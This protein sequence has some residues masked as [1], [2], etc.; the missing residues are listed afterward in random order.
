LVPLRVAASE[1][2]SALAGDYQPQ[3]AHDGSLQSKWVA[4]VESTPQSPQWITLR[5]AAARDVSAVA[6]YGEALDNDGLVAG[7]IQV[8][9][10]DGT[11]YQT[12]LDVPAAPARAWLATF[13]PVATTAVRLLITRS[14]GPS[15]HTDVYE[16]RL[17][18]PPLPPH[19][20]RAHATQQLAAAE[21]MLALDLEGLT[22]SPDAGLE[23]WVG[24]APQKLAL[25]ARYADV[26]RRLEAWDQ[27][28]PSSHVAFCDEVDRLA[29]QARQLHDAHGELTRVWTDRCA[30]VAAA[31]SADAET[32][33][34]PSAQRVVGQGAAVRVALS[35]DS[36]L[37]EAT[38]LGACHA[39][40]R[41]VAFAVEVDG[42]SFTPDGVPV[43]SRPF[44]SHLGSGTE[45]VQTWGH[46]V[47]VERRLQVF[48]DR[49]LVVVGGSVCNETDQEVS[50]GS[51]A[52]LNLARDGTG[53]W[54]A[55]Q[56][57]QS[58]GVVTLSGDSLWVCEPEGTELESADTDRSYAGT[59]LLALAQR[60]PA[61][62]LL[63]GFLTGRE[64]RPRVS[65]R[66]RALESGTALSATQDFLGRRLGPGE[67]IELDS[68]AVTAS[69]DPWSSL[70]A[71]GNDVAAAGV[72]PA[73]TRPTSLWCS[74]YAHRMAMTEDLVLANAAVA[75]QH[76][77]PLGMEIIQLDH[78]WQRGDVTGDWIPNERFP[79]GLPWLAEQ[80]RSKYGFRLGLWISPTDVADVSDLYRDHADWLLRDENG[81]PLRN[82]QWYW[83]PNPDCYE[84][85]ASHPDAADFLRETFARL[86]GEGVSY[87]KI[88]FLAPCGGDHFVQHDPSC[89][90]GWGVLQRAMEAIRAGA[91]PDAFIR[92]C[93]APPLLAVGLADGAYGGNDLLDGGRPDVM[94]VTREAAR[95]LA[96]SYWVHQRLYQREVCDLSIRVQADQE[97]VRLRLAL[98]ALAGCS[99]SLSDELQYLPSSRIR[100]AQQV[101]PPGTP[102][103]R[104]LDLFERAIPS[105]WHVRC[106][107]PF[108]QWHVVGLFN[109]EDQP[110]VRSV[111]LSDLGLAA[112]GSA[113]VFEFWE[114]RFVGVHPGRVE[115]ELPP[116]SSRVLFVHQM[117]GDPQLLGT[118]LHILGGY[119]ELSR[120]EWDADARELRGACRRMPGATG[121]V[122]VYLPETYAPKFDFPLAETS[123]RLTHVGN[124]VW[125]LELEF[126]DTEVEWTIPF[127]PAA[128]SP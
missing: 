4:A 58:P 43:T 41:G 53:W 11:D 70:E 110:Q 100:M 127:E 37:W 120:L 126:P 49:P 48:N 81:R 92:Y 26:R 107:R 46:G 82:W 8:L 114:E 101:L 13:P 88:D 84:L 40:L 121:R 65:A 79:H 21:A 124:R 99:I 117:T 102:P 73:R 87:F 33:A 122:Y 75:A 116:N 6:V 31:R 77:Q 108:A 83:K 54:H 39:A 111:E 29:A 90:R 16:I 44:E 12:V 105:V 91:G 61:T 27:H 112:D 60:N 63:V 123:A 10:P 7:A 15:P 109:L 80:L 94:P 98:L 59:M 104:P 25:R 128:D 89:T 76:F 5:L 66:F 55:G 125:M 30:E 51:A 23:Q 45:L 62:M 36:G 86:A 34:S 85:D 115:L 2:S 18:G 106:E 9:A 72:A 71:Y 22:T 52:L 42:T 119:H 47:R 96:A 113:L 74:W 38:W 68:V 50:L 17:Y 35:Q 57:L 32:A 64:A 93:Q 118:N 67:R 3:R 78:G 69:E 95:A 56:A 1:A 20:M 14:G 28:A 103:M 97:E 19:V 24:L